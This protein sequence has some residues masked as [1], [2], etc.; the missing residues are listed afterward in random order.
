LVP[1][2]LPLCTPLPSISAN[3]VPDIDTM[4]VIVLPLALLFAELASLLVVLMEVLTA[5]AP[6]AGMV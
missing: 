3:T 4:L 2:S 6:D 5:T 1:A